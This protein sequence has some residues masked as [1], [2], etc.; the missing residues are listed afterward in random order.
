MSTQQ[1]SPERPRV[2]IADD[3]PH[4]GEALRLA[5]R[6]EGF[7]IELAGSPAA[8]VDAIGARQFDL[9]LLDLNYARDTTSG[10]EGLALIE[11]VR[12]IDGDLAIVVMTAWGSI[13][14]AV[15]AMQRGAGDF[16]QKPWDNS[17]LRRILRTQLDRGRVRRAARRKEVAAEFERNEARETQQLLLPRSIPALPGFAIAA[18]CRPAGSL[19]GDYYDVLALGGDTAL[20][21]IGD[22]SGKGA[23]A[24]LVMA[25]LQAA[26]KAYAPENLSPVELVPQSESH[27]LRKLR[28]R[29][30]R[31]IFLLRARCAARNF[32]VRQRGS[33]CAAGCTSQRKHSETRRWRPGA[34]RIRRLV[35]GAGRNKIGFRRSGSDVYRWN[36]RSHQRSRR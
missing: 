16:I 3:Q 27:S 36:H 13:E 4:V 24:A 30:I 35:R 6:D 20:I 9:A 33:Q 12:K 14:V 21:C 28:A 32:Y 18:A 25:N 5:L 7:L 26:V 8:V 11:A 29:T 1:T 10:D 23:A 22:V 34:R 19:A 17:A 15:E 31:N 2:L